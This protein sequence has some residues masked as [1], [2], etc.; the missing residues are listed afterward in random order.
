MDWR[1]KLIV[2]SVL[3][4]VLEEV[5]EPKIIRKPRIQVGSGDPPD[6]TVFEWRIIPNKDKEVTRK[7]WK[8]FKRNQAKVKFNITHNFG[9]FTDLFQIEENVDKMFG[10]FMEMQLRD[11]NDD[12]AVSINIEH[13]QL[14]GKNLFIH[15]FR[16]RDFN[17]Q[18]FFNSIY[19]VSQSNTS[20]LLT[21]TLLLEINVTKNISGS[22]NKK[23]AP[24]T[25]EEKINS[26][27]SVIE[28]HNDDNGCAF[29]ALTVAIKKHEIPKKGKQNVYEWQCIRR[30][31]NNKQEDFAYH[32]AQICGYD[33][34]RPINID[35]FKK[36]QSHLEYQI[37]IIDGQ[38]KNNRLFVG[39]PIRSEKIYL[40]HRKTIDNSCH[41][42]AIVNIKGFMGLKFYCEH[43]HK[44]YSDIYKHS[45]GFICK[46]CHKYPPC[47]QSQTNIQCEICNINFL[48]MIVTQTI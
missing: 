31:T 18:C 22:G 16:K 27:R 5:S 13:S 6:R 46:C 17:N 45:C 7:Y 36:I 2:N 33:L 42:D 3:N 28:I 25:R 32:L 29:Y 44:S 19:E 34:T 30:N 38:N 23:K 15:P 24:K 14:K 8:I 26:S 35:D 12:D 1:S 4:N 9:S 39:S 37:I 21:G 48:V 43:C 47:L 20:F 11:F 40:L 41:F 10:D